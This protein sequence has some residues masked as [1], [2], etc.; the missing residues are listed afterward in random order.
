MMLVSLRSYS[1]GS[2]VVVRMLAVINESRVEHAQYRLCSSNLYVHG[3]CQDMHA[4]MSAIYTQCGFSFISSDCDI[5]NIAVWLNCH[6]YIY[7]SIN[8]SISADVTPILDKGGSRGVSKVPRNWSDHLWLVFA[9]I[10]LIMS[11]LPHNYTF[12]CW[13][14]VIKV[15]DPPQLEVIL[16]YLI[17]AK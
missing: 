11:M 4:C 16:T 9:C 14:P 12:M 2:T 1:T 5:L 3:Q 15:I 10:G 7:Q 8:Q 17:H 6:I 13:K